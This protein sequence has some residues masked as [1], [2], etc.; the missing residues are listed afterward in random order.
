MVAHLLVQEVAGVQPRQIVGDDHPAH[1][2]VQG[3]VGQ[4]Q[5]DMA[6][7]NLQELV[8][9][10]RKKSRL[11]MGYQN[12]PLGLIMDNQRSHNQRTGAGQLH[13]SGGWSLGLGPIVGDNHRLFGLADHSGE[14]GV[15][16][17]GLMQDSRNIG[18]MNHKLAGFLVKLENTAVIRLENLQLFG[19]LVDQT[20]LIDQEIGLLVELGVLK[21][22]TRGA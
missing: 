13:Q 10:V 9:V 16:I 5:P 21:G 2:R 8:I 14:P 12:G 22:R 3:G 18:R 20:Q 1:L 17:E 6:G 4:G 11:L 15:F 7:Q 19:Q